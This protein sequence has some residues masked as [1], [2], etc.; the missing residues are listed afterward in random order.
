MTAKWFRPSPVC[1]ITDTC[2]VGAML[3]GRESRYLQ[4][5]EDFGEEFGRN[6]Q[7]ESSAHGENISSLQDC[8][9]CCIFPGK[10]ILSKD[11]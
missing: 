7:S 10:E 1:R 4:E 2:R 6:M 8:A 11:K 3:T 9:K 5:P